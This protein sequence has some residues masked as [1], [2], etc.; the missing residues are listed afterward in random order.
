MDIARR[1]SGMNGIDIIYSGT[2]IAQAMVL[3][4]VKKRANMAKSTDM[5][6]G[7]RADVGN[8]LIKIQ[9][10][11]AWSSLPMK[12]KL[13]WKAIGVVGWCQSKLPQFKLDEPAAVKRRDTPLEAAETAR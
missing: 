10:F 4:W 8:V 9:M 2:T 1:N 11:V 12:Q 6:K 3:D 7:W 13:D 5:E